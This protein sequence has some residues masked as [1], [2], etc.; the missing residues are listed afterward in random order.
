[1]KRLFEVTRADWLSR[2][3]VETT[4]PGSPETQF[5][6]AGDFPPEQRAVMHFASAPRRS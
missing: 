2:R 5:T 6:D 1:M 4:P 3:W